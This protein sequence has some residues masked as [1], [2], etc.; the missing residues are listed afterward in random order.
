MADLNLSI[1]TGEV[2][3]TASTARTVLS[4][5]AP[6]NQRLKIFGF[7]IFGKGVSTTDTP[8]KCELYRVTTD[9]GTA[10]T[11]TPAPN[12]DD[13][14]ETPQGVYKGSYTVEPTTLGALLRTWEV[15]PQTGIIYMFPV[16][17]EIRVK[18]GK[19]V[20]LRLTSGQNETFAV[21]AIVEE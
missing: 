1:P 9:G 6:A 15:H 14:A 17:Q 20:A 19:E 5:T 12:D 8:V 10:T 2:S 16:G 11:I 18:G 3:L 4:I 13:E 21:N 7:E